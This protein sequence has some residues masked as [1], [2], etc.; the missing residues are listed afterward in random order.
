VRKPVNDEGWETVFHA[1]RAEINEQTV[2]G[3]RLTTTE[4]VTI[5]PSSAPST[6]LVQKGP[7]HVLWLV[8]LRDHHT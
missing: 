3:P 5:A 1:R 2:L 8:E 7:E 6:T 4:Q